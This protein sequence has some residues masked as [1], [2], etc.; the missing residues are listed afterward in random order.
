[1]LF[2]YTTSWNLASFA[3]SLNLLLHLHFPSDTHSFIRDCVYSTSL[4]LGRPKDLCLALSDHS[5]QCYS[6]LKHF[7]WFCVV[8]HTLL[9]LL[10]CCR[11]ISIEVSCDSWWLGHVTDLSDR[12]V[13]DRHSWEVAGA[14]DKTDALFNRDG[15]SN[16][17]C[18]SPSSKTSNAWEEDVEGMLLYGDGSSNG[19]SLSPSLTTGDV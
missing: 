13:Q 3:L 14:S 8:F 6:T 2:T 15:S 9:T 17:T 11:H 10:L 16:G 18:L 1:M 4:T 19:T 12:H 5:D 7:L